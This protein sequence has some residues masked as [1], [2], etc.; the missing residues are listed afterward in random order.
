MPIV[1]LTK[2]SSVLGLYFHWVLSLLKGFF[3]L[4]F[5]EIIIV[6]S[7]RIGQAFLRCKLSER[8]IEDKFWRAKTPDP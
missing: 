5:V 2:F 3:F 6:F 7:L 8:D 4:T 1:N